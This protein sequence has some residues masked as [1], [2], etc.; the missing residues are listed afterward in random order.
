MLSNSIV[1]TLGLNNFKVWPLVVLPGALVK[2]LSGLVR[3]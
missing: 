3:Y 2:I 1:L